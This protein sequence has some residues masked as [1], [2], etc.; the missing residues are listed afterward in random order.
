MTSQEYDVSSDEILT[1]ICAL[2]FSTIPSVL[3]ASEK[4]QEN[5]PNSGFCDIPLLSTIVMFLNL[6]SLLPRLPSHVYC[7]R[8]EAER[9]AHSNDSGSQMGL[10]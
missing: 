9:D 3:S 8:K 5:D 4:L 10:L 6:S 7:K 2:F 1:D